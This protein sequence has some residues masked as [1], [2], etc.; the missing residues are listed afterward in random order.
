VLRIASR[1]GKGAY[2][3]PLRGPRASKRRQLCSHRLDQRADAD[4]IHDPRQVV[5][6]HAQRRLRAQVLQPLHQEMGRPHPHLD[7]AAPAGVGPVAA[8]GQSV[9]LVRVVVDQTFPSGAQIDIVRGQIAKVLF[10]KLALGLVA[11]G[12][13]LWEGDGDT[14]LLSGQDL[15]AAE[16]AAVGH[17]IRFIDLERGFRLLGHGRES[18]AVVAD[19]GDLVG[20][21]QMMRGIDGGLYVA[22]HRAAAPAGDRNFPPEA[23][24]TSAGACPAGP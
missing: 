16:I 19:I 5:G 9:L 3:G 18:S 15:L 23:S 12:L 22:A 24:A 6:E 11:G 21:D 17:D 4:D 1:T 8:Q 7:R 2:E 10:D 14:G 13:R 20:H